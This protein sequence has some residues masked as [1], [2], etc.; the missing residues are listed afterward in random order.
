MEK[1]LLAVQKTFVAV[2][3]ALCLSINLPAAE[4]ARKPAILFYDFYSGRYHHAVIQELIEAGFE[5]AHRTE[6]F[7]EHRW[8]LTWDTVKQFNVIVMVGAANDFNKEHAELLDRF[9]DMGGGLLVMPIGG[10]DNDWTPSR[11][12]F[13][14]RLGLKIFI[15]QIKNPAK[16]FA[17]TG[18][19]GVMGCSIA[20]T[21][22][23]AASPITEGVKNLWYPVERGSFYY[24]TAP[25]WLAPE[26]QTLVKTGP[27]ASTVTKADGDYVH[28]GKSEVDSFSSFK[29]RSG[30]FSVVAV[31][32]LGKGRV[33][34]VGVHPQL[35]LWSG[36]IPAFGSVLM[37]TGAQGRPSDWSKL[38]VNL[39]LYL[40]EPSLKSG[41]LGGHVMR[42]EEVFAQPPGDPTVDFREE[43]EFPA[44]PD[45]VLVGIAGARSALSAGKNTVNEWKAA[46]R[47]AGYHFLIFLEDMT[48]MDAPRWLQLRKE[49]AENSDDDFLAF[50]G[51][52]FQT[53]LG[54]R[55]FYLDDL[56]Y[57]P[58]ADVFTRD[59]GRVR[60]S[61]GV[62]DQ[63]AK[64]DLMFRMGMAPAPGIAAWTDRHVPIGHFAHATNPTPFWNHNLYQVMSIFSRQ[65]GKALD[66]WTI[67]PY[68][69]VNAQKL[70]IAPFALELMDDVR[71]LPK[72]FQDG[73]A[74]LTYPGSP[75]QLHDLLS[76]IGA[77][78]YAGLCSPVS[79][80]GGPIIRQWDASG[81]LSYVV[82][83]WATGPSESDFY[84]TPNYRFRLRLAGESDAGVQEVEIYD[85]T[86]LYRRFLM[87]GKKS[88]EITTEAVNTGHGHFIAVVTDTKGRKAVTSE[89]ETENWLHRI[90]WCSDRCNFASRPHVH[91][92][93][94][95]NPVYTQT[96]GDE[97]CV[98]NR[99][100]FPVWG[101]DCGLVQGNVDTMFCKGAF[102][103]NGWVSYFDT[104]P[105]PEYTWTNREHAWYQNHARRFV[106]DADF[107]LQ[108]W[109]QSFS[110][111]APPS[112]NAPFYPYTEKED[113]FI[114]K[115]DV[116]FD[117]AESWSIA[118]IIRWQGQLDSK[119]PGE[120]ELRLGEKR[121]AGAIP[122]E[123]SNIHLTGPLPSGSLIAMRLNGA[124]GAHKAARAATAIV[125]GEGLSYR[126][127]VDYNGAA[128]RFQAGWQENGT[129]ARVGAWR[130]A[131]RFVVCNPHSLNSEDMTFASGM[132]PEF[133]GP[134]A[135]F[136]SALLDRLEKAD[137]YKVMRG[138][139][140][141]K[142]LPLGIH[143]D[144]GAASVRIPEVLFPINSL[145]MVISGLNPRWT[146]CYCELGEK[147][148]RRPVAVSPEGVA[149]VQ[150]D[151]RKK[152]VTVW[153][154][155][156]VV[157]S[158]KE[159]WF[160]LIDRGNGQ[161]LVEANNSADKELDV[162][163]HP[164][165][166]CPLLKF[167]PVKTKIAAGGRYQKELP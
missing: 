26:W 94:V 100:T 166:D 111:P 125:H 127:D 145:P 101:A 36:Y 133:S 87:N 132:A 49:C 140:E 16:T 116:V 106:P 112:G 82:P 61:R 85:G 148:M 90:Y 105:I 64:M 58:K 89:I 9:L 155:H 110:W 79:V 27:G 142:M 15:E 2:V 41:S 53:E 118:P 98:L 91:S 33:A 51:I 1:Y 30:D 13:E 146:A 123:G 32:E 164:N 20:W 154:G 141:D 139:V 129:T 42:K 122:T 25:L 113:I 109:D 158:H 152:D 14:E 162:A 124:G 75:A 50:P 119:R 73:A 12:Y 35:L 135:G 63:C 10:N 81:S 56:G 48:K 121:M 38:L 29:G 80:S 159:I 44:A 71:N 126:L 3:W 34:A 47:K 68:L 67:A 143:A 84:A 78:G 147:N 66:N 6:S 130:Q 57:W 97:R 165:T 22:A 120:Y 93:G 17:Y 137:W 59:G 144:D 153:V 45:Q 115:K 151:R 70:H 157:C 46:A 150:Y 60:S 74:C 65:N 8:T 4:S 19:G 108:G 69:E 37:K 107:A 28:S 138:T 31:R 88:L 43:E 76:R 114:F 72:P 52:E 55:G 95:G 163:F 39:Y 5:V 160:D 86:W 21:D 92:A 24:N 136:S 7:P 18:A 62:G 167:D 104:E 54:D 102:P 83:R 161:W 103:D 77:Y 117:G 131:R 134:E 156:P 149:R 128:F 40:A 99:W 23:I 96:M 11:S